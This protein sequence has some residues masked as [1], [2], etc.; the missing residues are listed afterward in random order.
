MAGA[1]T[2]GLVIGAPILLDSSNNIVVDNIG[3]CG[4]VDVDNFNYRLLSNSL[5][6]DAGL[7]I[8]ASIGGYQ[9]TP[10]KM[11]KDTCDF[12]DRININSI[13]IGAYEFAPI[14]S[15]HEAE[16]KSYFSIHP[17]PASDYIN[18][19]FSGIEKDPTIQIYNTFG[20]VLKE[21]LISNNNTLNISDLPNGIYFI[22]LKN[23][24]I[25]ALKFIK[26]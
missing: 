17:N 25:E 5:A 18:I 20:T 8:N 24:S 13:D 26:K 21:V 6:I 3:N 15:G 7:Y 12:E 14:T 4:F 11:Y 16:P 19:H 23:T 9:L 10:D 1:K 22:C 2:G